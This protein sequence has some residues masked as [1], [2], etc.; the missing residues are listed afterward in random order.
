MSLESESIVT[1][2]T[3]VNRRGRQPAVRP[4]GTV[5]FSFQSL[6]LDRKLDV[7]HLGI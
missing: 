3:S 4:T 5:S 6:R 1:G 7:A 2:L